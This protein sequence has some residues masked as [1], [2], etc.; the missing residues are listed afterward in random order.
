MLRAWISLGGFR[1]RLFGPFKS[2]CPRGDDFG[3]PFS[4]R[5]TVLG[6]RFARKSPESWF[7]VPELSANGTGSPEFSLWICSVGRK[8]VKKGSV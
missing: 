3:A 6:S 8:L 4:R 1:H 5:A 7:L 2:S